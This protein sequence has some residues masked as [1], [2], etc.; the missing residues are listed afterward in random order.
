MRDE[1]T[2]LGLLEDE[3][4]GIERFG[5]SHPGKIVG[6][7]IHFGLKVPEI[8]FAKATVDAVGDDDQIGGG[9]ARFILDL[10]LELQ[11]YA[12][13]ARTLLKDQQ[14]FA[15]GAAAKAIAA[16]PVHRAA[17]MHGD[18]VPIGEFLGNAAIARRIIL[19][20]IVERG[21]RK[22]HAKAES[23]IGPVAF[24]ERDLGLR[25]LLLQQD[26]SIET[27]RAT[28]DDRDFHE[29]LRSGHYTKYFKPKIFGDKP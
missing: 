1:G 12:E 26:R 3:R 4:E 17:E 27:S 11:V 24:I 15:T 21:V 16:N 7:D 28:T 6:A 14:Q 2:P 23:I 5:R 10:D 13:L 9:E 20:E 8:F 19:L 29:R 22:H 18:V 25:P